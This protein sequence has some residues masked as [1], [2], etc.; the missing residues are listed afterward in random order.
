MGTEE[1]LLN[2]FA[3]DSKPRPLQGTHSETPSENM[4]AEGPVNQGE[5]EITHF[6]G[7][8]NDDINEIAP[9]GNGSLMDNDDKELHYGS[10]DNIKLGKSARALSIKLKC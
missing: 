5:R 3:G 6:S 8:R 7:Q 9:P 4:K 1:N 2:F 10:Q